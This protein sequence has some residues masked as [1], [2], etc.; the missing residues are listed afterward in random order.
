VDAGRILK[1]Y[2]LPWTDF[3]CDQN[4]QLA[5]HLHAVCRKA[6]VPVEF[7]MYSGYQSQRTKEHY[8]VDWARLA[9]HLD[10]AI[11]GYG[12]G[13]EQ[14]RATVEALQGVPFMGG[15]MWYLSDRNDQRP[16]P[17]AETWRNRVLRQFVESGCNGCLF[18]WLPPMDGGSFLATSEAAALIAEHEDVLQAEN[19]CDAEVTV[20]GLRETNWAA[21]RAGGRVLVLLMSFQKDAADVA[22]TLGSLKR[23]VSVPPYGTEVLFLKR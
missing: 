8:G 21:F 1:Q 7:S 19:R 9:P 12:G 13:R 20:E 4:A 17:R 6:A 15:E 2:R 18:W 10:F 3:R 5:G 14:I 23:T 11:A 22:V 16:T